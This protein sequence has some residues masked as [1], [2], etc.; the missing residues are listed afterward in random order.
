M[1]VTQ[2]LANAVTSFGSTTLPGIIDKLTAA[3]A[4]DEAQALQAFH[5]DI[6]Q[7][8]SAESAMVAQIEAAGNRLIDRLN[9]AKLTLGSDISPYGFTLSIPPSTKP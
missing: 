2:S 8:I 9:G 4:A 1:D 6:A 5:D 7:I 3:G